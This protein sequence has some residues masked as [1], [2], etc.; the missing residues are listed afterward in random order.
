MMAERF[1]SVPTLALLGGAALLLT[2]CGG[3]DIA[4]RKRPD[5]FAIGKQAPL[6]VPPDFNMAPPR[7]GAP[8]P[9]GADSQQQALEAL[10]GPGVQLPPR[11]EIENQLLSD[12][13]AMRTD[14]NIRATVDDAP[15][16]MATSTVDKGAFLRELIDAPAG[17][18]NADI[19]RVTIP[20]A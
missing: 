10:F 9:I 20:G 8:R 16:T 1:S 7:P 6:V 19:A 5:E 13:K 12:A 3:N 17:T 11:S 4:D 18:R 15:G 14:V 2:A